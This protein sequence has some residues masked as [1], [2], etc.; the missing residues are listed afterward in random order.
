MLQSRI[1]IVA[2]MSFKRYPQNKSLANNCEFSGSFEPD[3]NIALIGLGMIWL[4][5]PD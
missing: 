3:Q 4:I 2:S 5:T 1:I